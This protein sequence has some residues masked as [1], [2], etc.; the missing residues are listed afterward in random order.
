MVG[1][2]NLEV[3]ED[4]VEIREKKLNNA[5]GLL[6]SNARSWQLQVAAQHRTNETFCRSLPHQEQNPCW[7]EELNI[8]LEGGSK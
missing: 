5:K 8:I 3:G 6:S 1:G 7:E 2:K 4:P